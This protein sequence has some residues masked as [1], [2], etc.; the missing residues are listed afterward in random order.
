MKVA[1][2]VN[3][4]WAAYN[5]RVNL[6]LAMVSK[7]YEV[8]FIVPYDGKYSEKLKKNFQCHNLFIDPKSLSPI[9][10][11]RTF[12]NLLNI[13][14]KVKP[15]IVCHFTIKLNIYGS[16]VA[17]I[18]KIPSISNITGLGTLF[19]ENNLV[20]FF[21][22]LL[23]KFSLSFPEK[24]FFQNIEDQNYFFYNKLVHFDANTAL[25]PGSGVD[26]EKFKFSTSV[27]QKDKFV[28]LLISRLLRDKGIYDYID[29]IKIVK[30]RFPDKIIEFQLLG[31]VGTN[32]R[33]AIQ[34]NEL[35]DWVN[36]NLISYLGI[37]DKVEQVI[38]GCDC[39]VLPSYREGMPRS[40][41]EAF[42]IG[43]PAIASDV[44]GCRGIVE[45]KANGL[46]CKVKSP[47]DL[48]R[49]MITMMRI[50]K[51]C[52]YKLSENGRSKVEH[53]FDEKI[54]I[55]NYIESINNIAAYEK[56]I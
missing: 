40:I 41:L 26:L 36:D 10:E 7:G 19:I 35:D 48:A 37:S 54:V 39:V 46:L 29:A 53:F 21:A 5:F 47:P 4:A 52:R 42:A 13:Y 24:I 25:L 6:A 11:I 15:N 38:T 8:I 14:K 12:I 27:I 22:K 17:R 32:N 20:T 3:S 23:Y 50:S 51:E 28:F 16:I 18:F 30:R 55:N 44:P 45:H 9:K 2:V 34:M 43:R 33:T 1:I 49:K 31:E 56:I